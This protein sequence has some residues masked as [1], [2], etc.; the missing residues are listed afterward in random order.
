MVSPGVEVGARVPAARALAEPPAGRPCDRGTRRRR[1]TA[2]AAS[3]LGRTIPA[4]PAATAASTGAKSA[5]MSPSSW[6]LAA[7]VCA[8]AAAVIERNDAVTTRR[9]KAIPLIA[10]YWSH[11]P[12]AM[13]PA[14]GR[15]GGRSTACRRTCLSLSACKTP[16]PRS[17]EVF[18]IAMPAPSGRKAAR[19][20]RNGSTRPAA[21]STPPRG[22]A[23]CWCAP[24]TVASS[25][26]RQVACGNTRSSSSAWRASLRSQ[27]NQMIEIVDLERQLGGADA[28]AR[29][30]AS[31]SGESWHPTFAFRFGIA[32]RQC[33]IRLTA[34]FGTWWAMTRS[35]DASVLTAS[36][37]R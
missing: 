19:R 16:W 10:G 17:H 6:M 22:S 24:C 2:R 18:V 29:R 37:T 11:T 5:A 9:T 15:S 27:L 12:Y 36:T 3:T 8:S 25:R 20:P 35:P 32:A 33:R 14:F 23:C 28:M 26:S 4:T 7:I 30:L 1:A 13:R 21:R 34:T 31:C